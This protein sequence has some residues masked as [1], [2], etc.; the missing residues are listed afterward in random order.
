LVDAH[1]PTSDGRELVFWRHTQPEKDQ[2]LL[3]VQLGWELP[4]QA[5]PRISSQGA[6][7]CPAA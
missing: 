5:P 2:K 1:I 4:E 7:K 3:L 6:L